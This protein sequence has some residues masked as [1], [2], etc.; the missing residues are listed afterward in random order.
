MPKEFDPSKFLKQAND[1]IE[2]A[3]TRKAALETKKVEAAKKVAAAEEAQK[4]AAA[5][6]QKAVDDAKAKV[7]SLEE[8]IAAEDSLIARTQLFVDGRS[9]NVVEQPP[10]QVINTEGVPSEGEFGQF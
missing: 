7:T 3:K 10:A 2:A 6:K 5:A 9:E 4:A 8:K 1:T